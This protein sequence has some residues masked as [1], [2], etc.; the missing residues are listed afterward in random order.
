[1]KLPVNTIAADLRREAREHQAREERQHRRE[2]ATPAPRKP[3]VKHAKTGRAT[4]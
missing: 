4:R 2:L 1:M 3:R